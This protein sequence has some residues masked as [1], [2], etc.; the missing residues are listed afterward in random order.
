MFAKHLTQNKLAERWNR[1]PRTLE[2]WRWLGIGPV[3][4]KIG[5]SVVY[6]LEDVEAYEAERSRWKSSVHTPRLPPGSG[7]QTPAFGVLGHPRLR[8][9]KHSL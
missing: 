7:N 1:S 9:P 6:R 4:L 5:G 3:Y 2:R 8:P